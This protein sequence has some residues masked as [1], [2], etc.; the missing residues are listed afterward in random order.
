MYFIQQVDWYRMAI[1]FYFLTPKNLKQHQPLF[2]TYMVMNQLTKL[3]GIHE[4]I[5]ILLKI[6][7]R[8]FIPATSFCGGL[9]E[10]HF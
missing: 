1:H 3:N 8:L 5:W 9:A 2:T 7:L 10:V 4:W 6:I